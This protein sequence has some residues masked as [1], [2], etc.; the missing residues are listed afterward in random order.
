M[1]QSDLYDACKPIRD[2]AVERFTEY[3]VKEVVKDEQ[4]EALASMKLGVHLSTLFSTYIGRLVEEL[5]DDPDKAEIARDVAAY[6]VAYVLANLAKN[7]LMTDPDEPVSARSAH[8]SLEI[9][10]D[11][12]IPMAFRMATEIDHGG[13]KKFGVRMGSDGSLEPREDTPLDTV[14]IVSVA[15]H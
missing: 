11:G 3:T 6:G 15:R 2:A 10:L 4:F 1:E 12:I 7:M 9:W 8:G 14:N 13:A 5:K